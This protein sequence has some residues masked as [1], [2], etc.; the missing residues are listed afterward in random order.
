MTRS[1][2]KAQIDNFLFAVHNFIFDCLLWLNPTIKKHLKRNSELKNKHLGDSCI[3]FGNGPSLKN[4]D[5]SQINNK[6]TFVVN[7]FYK[8][9]SLN[10]ISPDYYVLLDELFYDEKIDAFDSA[11]AMFPR[12]V[13]LFKTNCLG[14]KVFS[15]ILASGV[16]YYLSYSQS[17]LIDFQIHYEQTKNITASVNVV[18]HCIQT[19]IYMGFK[20]I[21][22]VGCDF[23]SFSS[24]RPLYAYDIGNDVKELSLGDELKFY[25]VVCYHHY[26]L[27][28]LA[29]DMGVKIVNATQ[30]SLLDAYPI[31][32]IE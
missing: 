8:N 6:K 2:I 17:A 5:V 15:R 24:S 23:N 16:K 19:A 26:A 4:F 30:G 28:K 13:F 31:G 18:N 14:Y 27:A 3:V 9:N 22:L 32:G 29:N 11:V 7:Y 20:E 25:S 12:S 21:F 1:G 10:I